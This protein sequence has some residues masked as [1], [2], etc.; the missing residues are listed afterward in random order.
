MSSAST[1]GTPKF[2]RV[3]MKTSSAPARIA[4]STIGKVTVQHGAAR[5]GAQPLRRLLH[6]DVDRLEGGDG[7]QQHVGI[8]RQRVDQ[9]DAAGAVDRA[10]AHAPGLQP[11]GD[12]AGTAEQQDDGIGA[13][14]GRQHQRQGG[15]GEDRGLAG[16]RQAGEREGEGHGE[17]RRDHRR[18]QPDAQ[19]V[20]DGGAIERPAQHLG[21]V[22]QGQPL[23]VGIEQA[24]AEDVEQ[25]IEQEEAEEEEAQGRDGERQALAMGD[26]TSVTAAPSGAPDRRRA[27][28]RRRPAP[29]TPA[30]R[31]SL[32]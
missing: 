3:S 24:G 7:R 20:E 11:L 13:D 29:G 5:R 27:S 18:G 10:E 4:G 9:H 12:D 30:H 17:R 14:E 2:S 28:P 31:A 15:Q 22:G 23:A 25:R 26:R 6:R 16:D 8:E 21:V 19:R 32:P 1:K